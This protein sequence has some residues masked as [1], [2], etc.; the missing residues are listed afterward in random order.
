MDPAKTTGGV[1]QASAATLAAAAPAAEFE[2]YPLTRPEYINA[3]IHFYRGELGRAN[4]WRA[5]IDQTTNWS[6]AL[7]A[8]LLSFAFGAEDHDHVTL[9]LGN[10][11]V[12]VFLFFEA[13]RFRRYDAWYARVRMIEE[14]FYIPILLRDLVS[15][16]ER[17]R[18]TIAEDLMRPRYKISLA[19]A[20]GIRLARNYIWMFMILLAGWLAKITIHH[21]GKPATSFHEMF[22][23]MAVGPIPSGVVLGTV[24]L[25]Y[26]G[27]VAYTVL[28]HS[29]CWTARSSRKKSSAAADGSSSRTSGKAP[30]ILSFALPACATIQFNP[31][32]CHRL[33]H[34]FATHLLQLGY[35]I[36]ATQ[37]LPGRAT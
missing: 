11:L 35:D 34:S 9:L 4:A 31:A 18:A 14:N 37:E 12:L 5:R 15:P 25:F 17:W 22:Q 13:R 16:M 33:S 20:F 30:R 3:L 6:V 23:G 29:R 21:T 1:A 36:R 10:L 24:I 2:S 27:L 19:E 26:G 32:S 28:F 8:G 7:V